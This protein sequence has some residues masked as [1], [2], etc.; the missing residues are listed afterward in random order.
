MSQRI[1]D[2]EI[3]AQMTEKGG[4]TKSTLAKWGVPWPPPHG[5]KARLITH[6]VPYEPSPHTRR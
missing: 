6:G 2:E 5:W 4:Y 3:V 1:T